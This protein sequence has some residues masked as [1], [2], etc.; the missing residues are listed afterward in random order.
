M[1]LLR[2]GE[3]PADE[4]SLQ[5]VEHDALRLRGRPLVPPAPARAGREQR[6]ACHSAVIRPGFGVDNPVT[7]QQPDSPRCASGRARVVASRSSSQTEQEAEVHVV[8]IGCGRVGSELAGALEQA[9]HTVAVVDK[10]A[11]AFRRLP[12]G[13]R[14]HAPWS[15]SASTATTSRRPASTRPRRSRRSRA[16]TTPTS[17]A[18][19][20]PARP[21]AS[22]TSSPASTT[23]GAR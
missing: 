18:P 21:T 12:P 17:C 9:D 19:G 1:L 11:R 22:S 2:R 5:R 23:R 20:S 7:L 15:A 13:L 6:S 4:Q 10:N 16:A 8:V 14:R 3:R